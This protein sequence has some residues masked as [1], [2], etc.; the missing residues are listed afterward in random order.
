MNYTLHQLKVFL[1][2]AEFRSITKA[3][4]ALHLSQPAVSI[5]LKNF[6]DQFDIPLTEVIGR[7]LY[8]TEFGEEIARAARKIISEVEEIDNKIL[9]YQGRISGTLNVS[10][11]STG[12]YVMPFILADFLKE[13]SGVELVMDVTN[14]TE[15]V[16]SLVDNSVDFS[17]VSIQPER[18]Q[19]R[20][21]SLMENKLYLVV[22]KETELSEKQVYPIDI[23]KKV[24][25]IFRE[26]GSGT[27][28]T[29][30]RFLK[31]NNLSIS[32]KLE[33][34]TNE[35]VKQAVLAGL[36][37]S[38]MPLIGIRNEIKKGE[39]KIIPVEGFPLV[40]QWQLVWLKEKKH[41]PAARAYLEYLHAEKE[42]IVDSKFK[43]YNEFH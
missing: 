21:I 10:V 36:G 40:S 28:E 24:E 23:L 5:Q 15:V 2:I 18:M 32:K 25:L 34:K 9:S 39:L 12:K 26:S 7:Q 42:E 1:S 20:S 31:H 14:K 19:L 43:W 30:E 38:I 17:L 6:Q 22:N 13:H 3:A 37:C 27:R 8:I 33:L 41:S 35:A 4:E 16:Q 29:V 11:V